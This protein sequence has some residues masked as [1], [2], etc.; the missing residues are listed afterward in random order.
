M[1]R[2]GGV[3]KERDACGRELGPPRSTQGPEKGDGGGKNRPLPSACRRP[4]PRLIILVIMLSLSLSS[5][6]SFL[7][8]SSNQSSPH[9]QNPSILRLVI[10][11]LSWSSYLYPFIFPIILVVS[12]LSS[13]YLGH[14]NHSQ[15]ILQCQ[16]LQLISTMY[17]ITINYIP[18]SVTALVVSYFSSQPSFTKEF[19]KISFLKTWTF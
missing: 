17:S 14:P 16:C 9:P 15:S 10:L 3:G 2:E 18:D 5:S 19:T 4:F 11:L 12:L 13:S 1:G 7:S 6:S 8:S